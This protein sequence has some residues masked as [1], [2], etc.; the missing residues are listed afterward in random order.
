[1]NSG[2]ITPD[3][4]AIPDDKTRFVTTVKQG[5]NNKMPPWADVLSE[6]EIDVSVVLCRAGGD[7]GN[8]FR[9]QKRHR[10][11]CCRAP[12]AARAADAQPLKVCL[13]EDRPPLSSHP[14]GKPGAGFDVTLAQAVADRLGRPLAIQWFETKLDEDASPQLEGQRAAVRRALLAGQRLRTDQGFAGR[15]RHEDRAHA[16]F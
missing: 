15:A 2:T 13:D 1:M 6:E 11:P 7:R 4:R 14:R 9:S 8:R 10:K 5:K 3:L 16:G 12:A